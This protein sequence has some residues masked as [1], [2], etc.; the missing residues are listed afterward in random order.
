MPKI[1]AATVSAHRDLRRGMILA[2][3]EALL[4]EG[5][6]GAV[7]PG[8]VAQ[9]IGLS[10]TA[11]YKYFASGTQILQAIVEASFFDWSQAVGQAVD[12][13]PTVEAKIDAYIETTLSLGVAGAHRIAV[14]AGGI[15]V[16]ETSQAELTAQHKG[17]SVHLANVLASGGV[18]NAALLADL[19][20]GILGKA[21]AQIDAGESVHLVTEEATAMVKR[22]L[23]LPE[24]QE[25]EESR[26]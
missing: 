12:A 8:A 24:L 6:I 4:V 23:A 22:A 21:I 26:T 2:A 19:V 3:A 14:L 17:L 18:Q 11:I 25:P 16:D 13:A 9:E 7:T 1:E 10:R 5:G 15:P 20:D